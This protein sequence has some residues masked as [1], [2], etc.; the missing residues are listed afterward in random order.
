MSVYAFILAETSRQSISQ[1][2]WLRINPSVTILLQAGCYNI[3]TDW[4]LQNYN[5][6]AE[7]QPLYYNTITGWLLQNYYRL[8]EDQPL[9]Y[10]IIIA[11][12][13]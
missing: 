13:S 3:I 9:C 1:T 6:L 12:G 5:R 8:A 11:M 10:N 7:D 4:L 2:G